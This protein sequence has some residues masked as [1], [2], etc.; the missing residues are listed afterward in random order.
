MPNFF[1]SSVSKPVSKQWTVN[2]GAGTVEVYEAPDGQIQWLAKF[3]DK[4]QEICA[5][6]IVGIPKE[7]ANN[8]KLLAQFV[9]KTD[10]YVR[11]ATLEDGSSKIYIQPRVRGGANITNDPDRFWPYAQV[12]IVVDCQSFGN[13]PVHLRQIIAAVKEWETKTEFTF[14]VHLKNLA[15][16]SPLT[17]EPQP[18]KLT[19][20]HDATQPIDSDSDHVFIQKFNDDCK[21]EQEET[22][23]GDTCNV[24]ESFVGRLGGM[25]VIS[26]KLGDSFNAQSVMHELGHALGFEHEQMRE[27]SKDYVRVNPKFKKNDANYGKSP[28]EYKHGPYDFASIMHYPFDK[29]GEEMQIRTPLPATQHAQIKALGMFGGSDLNEENRK[30]VY[31]PSPQATEIW[32]GV[33]VVGN[34]AGLSPGDIAAANH[35]AAQGIKL[36]QSSQE[37]QTEDAEY[38]EYSE[39]SVVYRA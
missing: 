4:I 26:C 5:Y 2:D 7:I 38:T 6:N 37:E 11:H 21:V 1:K 36:A 29:D 17:K 15:K 35:L 24:C 34:V 32:D 39:S 19:F 10:T 16:H 33:M 3:G 12:P 14:T 18:F 23:A 22:K 28:K 31:K 13:N 9:H 30:L 27:D 20:S 25:Q 8:P